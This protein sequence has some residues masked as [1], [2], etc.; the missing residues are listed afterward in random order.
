MYKG[1]KGYKGWNHSYPP[2]AYSPIKHAF[3][4]NC[5]TRVI[6]RYSRETRS[7]VCSKCYQEI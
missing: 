2:Q 7:M 1:Y 5:N 3:C 4:Y 6:A